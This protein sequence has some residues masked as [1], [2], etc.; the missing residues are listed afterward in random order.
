MICAELGL[1]VDHEISSNLI[2]SMD[3][4]VMPVQ[5]SLVQAKISCEMCEFAVSVIDE[6]LGDS[7][8][9]DMVEREVQFVCSYLPGTI[10]DKCEEMVDKYGEKL[11]EALIKEQMDPKKVRIS[12]HRVDLCAGVHGADPRL[13]LQGGGGALCLGA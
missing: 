8:T 7:A 6:R 5:G 3:L 9:I 12:T 4:V 13:W 2:P 10:A 1:C 11:I